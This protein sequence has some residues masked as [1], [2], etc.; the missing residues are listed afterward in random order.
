MSHFSSM[1]TLVLVSAKNRDNILAR[2]LGFRRQG[3]RE[4]RALGRIPNIFLPWLHMG[5]WSNP[6]SRT[7]LLKIWQTEGTGSEAH[8]EPNRKT[9]FTWSCGIQFR[10]Q[11]EPAAREDQGFTM[12]ICPWP[13]KTWKWTYHS[14]ANTK[15]L[16][17][18]DDCWWPRPLLRQSSR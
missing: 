10:P 4:E 5:S 8:C 1:V 3:I 7:R 12:R 17:G 14:K 18:Q 13:G 9:Q 2:Y 11:E 6:K 15:F 16:Q